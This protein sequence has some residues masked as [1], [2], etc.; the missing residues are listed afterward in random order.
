MF[1]CSDP[2]AIATGATR[3][4]P[5]GVNHRPVP[6]RRATGRVHL[7]ICAVTGCISLVWFHTFTEP[8]W[9]RRRQPCQ[10]PNDLCIA[11]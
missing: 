3:G 4:E 9:S 7:H 6:P 8:V 5:R 2:K 1:A 10:R 11:F